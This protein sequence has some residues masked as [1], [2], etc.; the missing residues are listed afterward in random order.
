MLRH[1]Y[2]KL[3]DMEIN[4]NS[5]QGYLG[6]DL[7]KQTGYLI[8]TAHKRPLNQVV[9]ME[10]LIQTH[11]IQVITSQNWMELIANQYGLWG[12]ENKGDRALTDT[13]QQNIW[14]LSTLNF[15]GFKNHIK[16][17]TFTFYPYYKMKFVSEL[18]GS[19]QDAYLTAENLSTLFSLQRIDTSIFRP[20]GATTLELTSSQWSTHAKAHN[21]LDAFNFQTEGCDNTGVNF[22]SVEYP[23]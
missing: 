9:D 22:K 18:D 1:T 17:Q 21:L 4:Q 5:L 15:K 10:D 2:Q 20:K 6:Q 16:E 11:I 3:T 23:C 12:K 13:A 8:L 19:E 14:K 7:L